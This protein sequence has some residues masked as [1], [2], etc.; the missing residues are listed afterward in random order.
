MSGNSER[1]ETHELFKK[2]T[3]PETWLVVLNDEDGYF[4][5]M[6]EAL[7]MAPL[8]E[9]ELLARGK[10]PADDPVH[11]DAWIYRE[12]TRARSL[13]RR[14]AEFPIQSLAATCE[15]E[16]SS[17]FY[18][19]CLAP[20]FG[21]TQKIRYTPTVEY[22]RADRQVVTTLGKFLTKHYSSRLSAELIRFWQNKWVALSTPAEIHFAET[23][24]EVEHV[25]T[26]GPHSC[27][28][29][30]YPG[31][32]ASNEHP[33]RLWGYCTDTRVAY[34]KNDDG[35]IE[36]RALVREDKKYWMRLYPAD[37]PRF[38]Q[39]LTQAGYRHGSLDGL[40]VPI[41][42]QQNGRRGALMPYCDGVGYGVISHDGKSIILR[43][44][45]GEFSV[46]RT[47]GICELD[48]DREDMYTCDCGHEF[49]DEDE[50]SRSDDDHNYCRYCDDSFV[51]A[52][53]RR[54]DNVTVH[55]DNAIYIESM[56]AYIVD[57][58]RALD[59]NGIV[60]LESGELTHKD[61][62]T[63]L[64]DGRWVEDDNAI[65][66]EDGTVVHVDEAVY[67]RDEGVYVLPEDAVRNENHTWV[68]RVEE[69]D[70]AEPVVPTIHISR[71]D[72]V[73]IEMAGQQ[74]LPIEEEEE[75]EQFAPIP[76]DGST[77][78]ESM[79]GWILFR[80]DHGH[81]PQQIADLHK[82]EGATRRLRV[83]D[84]VAILVKYGR[85]PNVL[86]PD[87]QVR[88]VNV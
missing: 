61:D 81:S 87:A 76:D 63:Q 42:R 85:L 32:Y 6:L 64:D 33:A 49:D 7:N 62:A 84:V 11:L 47:D 15:P 57:D 13:W 65:E 66:L 79:H 36:A 17:D 30:E 22:G 51:T 82:T 1:S 4:Y 9:D 70:A 14:L 21:D 73:E 41:V 37:K 26:N 16:D 31:E 67:L 29:H 43:E 53:N 46:Q 77:L 23:P 25:Y 80:F 83:A 20:S 27:M 50:I 8:D 5:P 35:D 39:A 54:C 40:K 45:D 10:L 72:P 74:V 28:A 88:I 78:A 68:R 52:L 48:G 55:R 56:D 12:A 58:A 44:A 69:E 3:G 18:R 71:A 38:M 59:A 75:E 86:L 2:L 34:M 60:R 19:W 24:E